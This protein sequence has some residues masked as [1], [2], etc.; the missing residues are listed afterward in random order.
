MTFAVAQTL[1]SSRLDYCN[2]R[3]HDIALNDISKLQRVQNC[4]ARVVTRSPRFSHSE[5]FLK[6]LHWLLV[7]Y[8]IILKICTV[9]YQAHS[10]KQP[11]YI[12]LL[13]PTRKHRQ[14]RSSNSNVLF[15]PSVKTNVELELFQ[16]LHRLC[17]TRSQ[18]VLK[19]ICKGRMHLL[20]FIRSGYNCIPLFIS[21]HE[22]VKSYINLA[23]KLGMYVNSRRHFSKKFDDFCR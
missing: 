5:L 1:V 4:L 11:A 10:S 14:L 21:S 3:Y 2:S 22:I 18:L 7:R 9:T 20:V 8:R 19:I 17:G 15:V 23:I 12:S 6:S 13:T 16:L